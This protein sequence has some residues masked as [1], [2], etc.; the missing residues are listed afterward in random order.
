MKRSV[1]MARAGIPR[2]RPGAP[3]PY[4]KVGTKGGPKLNFKAPRM[5]PQTLWSAMR[6][7]VWAAVDRFVERNK[8]RARG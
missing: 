7:S 4:K 5:M 8:P 6:Q 2:A 1:E 3:V